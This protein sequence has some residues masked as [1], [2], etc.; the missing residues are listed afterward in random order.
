MAT[1]KKK[2][3]DRVGVL[4][5]RLEEIYGRMESI[6]ENIGKVLSKLI[7]IEKMEQLMDRLGA[8]NHIE[9]KER[10]KGIQ[11]ESSHTP[12]QFCNAESN[13]EHLRELLM[14]SNRWEHRQQRRLEMPVFVGENLDSR[15]YRAERYF[16]VNLLTE[17]ERLEGSRVVLRRRGLGFVSKGRTPSPNEEMGRDESIVDGEVPIIT[18]REVWEQFGRDRCHWANFGY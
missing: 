14:E 10:R 12:T 8:E 3:E 13:Q 5:A 6:K 1:S 11:P 16:N 18:G 17:L 15:I 7:A 2:L 9:F 4:E